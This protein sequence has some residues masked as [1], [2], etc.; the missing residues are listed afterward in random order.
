MYII[1]KLLRSP[2]SINIKTE[3]FATGSK[4][5]GGPPGHAKPPTPVSPCPQA[6]ALGPSPVFWVGQASP[7]SALDPVSSCSCCQ[8][9]PLAGLSPA[10]SLTFLG[11]NDRASEPPLTAW[12]NGTWSPDDLDAPHRPLSPSSLSLR[13]HPDHPYCWV[14]GL[15]LFFSITAGLQRSV[16]FLLYHMVTQLMYTFFFFP[17][18]CSIVNDQTQFPALHSRISLLQ[19]IGLLLMPRP[20]PTP[21][22]CKLHV[23]RNLVCW[24]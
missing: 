24:W 12:L 2:T 7:T 14:T 3:V 16:D 15:F 1:Q 10:F 8:E 18:S 11:S 4:A 21:V 17:L 20:Q 5:P 9:A 22:E 23:W 19:V 13:C 6:L